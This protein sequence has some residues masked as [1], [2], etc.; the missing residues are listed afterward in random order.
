[1]EL[2]LTEEVEDLGEV[3]ETVE[4]SDGYGRNYLLP[5]GL[6]VEPTVGNKRRYEK[7][8]KELSQ[9]KE[10]RRERAEERAEE[11]DGLELKFYR[12]AQEERHLY[13]SVRN[14]DIVDSIKEETGIDLAPE[15]VS[16][17][18]PI[19]ELGQY[20]VEIRLYEEIH[21]NIKVNVEEEE[22]TEENQGEE[23]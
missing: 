10:E 5:K 2:I 22:S 9:R 8:R 13:G 14:K 3:G 15:A 7:V 19:E 17:D 4:V 20:G 23:G 11:L 12:K 18:S 6:A 16:L 1:M 21:A